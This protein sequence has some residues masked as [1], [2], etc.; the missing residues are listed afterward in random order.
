MS[1]DIRFSSFLRHAGIV[2]VP[3]ITSAIHGGSEPRAE[4]HRDA[5]AFII[6]MITGASAA[7]LMERDWGDSGENLS[8]LG[9]GEKA[10]VSTR[11]TSYTGQLVASVVL[12]IAIGVE[13]KSTQYWGYTIAVGA[14][15]AA[16]ALTELL[17]LAFQ[18]SDKILFVAPVL[19]DMTESGVLALFLL[20]WWGVGTY[21]I[22]FIA[23]FTTTSNGYFAAWMGFVCS[24]GS[25]G[26]TLP[27]LAASGIAQFS[28]T[29]LI[30]L[31]VC[32]VVVALELGDEGGL[33]HQ[34]VYGMIVSVLTFSLVAVTLLQELAGAPLDA[35]LARSL[36]MVITLLWGFA[37]LWLTSTGPFAATSNAYFALWAGL[38][39]ASRLVLDVQKASGVVAA[40]ANES[41]AALWG[42]FVAANV[43]L[44]AVSALDV[45]NTMNWG[46]ALAV[47]IV[48]GGL[49][50]I[51]ALLFE[52]P[53]GR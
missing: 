23:P 9:G 39:C 34:M 24:V 36:H 31:G 21:V 25:A 37:A 7:P 51:S 13:D 10:T 38:V 11:A 2:H 50:L 43:L 40:L 5:P 30:G 35:T 17:L 53:A 18:K 20:V 12:I 45:E 27:R 33:S 44:L 29:S 28:S 15:S 48:A 52:N 42:Q 22:T 26:A 6:V 32:A 49:A 3:V 8:A 19:G 41:F 4:A 47:A 1:S 14:V 46:Y 16:I